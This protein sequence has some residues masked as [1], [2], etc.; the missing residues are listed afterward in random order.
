MTKLTDGSRSTNPVR[1]VLIGWPY[2]LFR[3]SADRGFPE[4]IW[5]ATIP[6]VGLAVSIEL[7]TLHYFPEPGI[8]KTARA[9]ASATLVLFLYAVILLYSIVVGV[10]VRLFG[11]Q[12]ESPPPRRAKSGPDDSI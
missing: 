1:L 6:I 3:Y 5:L 10:L 9:G 7:L 8:S 11:H 4:L 2:K 12:E